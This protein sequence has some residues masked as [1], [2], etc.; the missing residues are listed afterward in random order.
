MEQIT[1]LKQ[2]NEVLKKYLGQNSSFN[3]KKV[4]LDRMIPLMDL[5]GNPQ[6]KLKIIHIA[7]TSGKTSTAYF[8]SELLKQSGLNTGL[9][10]S[11]YIDNI[12]ERVQIN[13]QPLPKIRFCQE[14]TE[15]LN[16]I[17]KLEVKPS[18]FEL[19]CAFA[20]WI[21]AK[22]KV[23]YAII[24]TGLGGLLDATNVAKRPDKVCVITDIGYDHIKILGNTLEEI[25]RQKAGIIHKNNPVIM[26]R[27]AQNITHIFAEK[28]KETQSKLILLNEED[29]KHK[30]DT[31]IN[32]NLPNFQKRNWLLAHQVYLAI[33]NRDNLKIINNKELLKT[34]NINI[35][36]RME[37]INKKDKIII[38]DGAHNEQKMLAFINNFKQKYPNEK[39]AILISL[40]QDKDFKKILPI[41]KNIA[42]RIITTN[43]NTSQ[44]LM[45]K[46]IPARVLAD[47]F[48]NLEIL[49]V[50]AIDNQH[51]AY[52]SLLN[53]PERICVITGSLYL[54]GQIRKT[55]RLN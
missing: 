12:N 39:P 41:F 46:S 2:A 36:A 38:M 44:D 48:A 5:L 14:L 31:L 35:P 8:I 37:V 22:E 21:F 11:P 23:D 52:Q 29:L 6:D 51:L 34:Q 24:E 33:A 1:S 27:Q 7:G 10:V 17:S 20:Y 45:V 43:F 16:I 50:E 47:G 18:Y 49:N 40:K 53:G 30:Y 26:Y 42:N 28:C 25:S 15:F 54:I 19:L 55:E 9:T 13:N 4:N 3:K 32:N